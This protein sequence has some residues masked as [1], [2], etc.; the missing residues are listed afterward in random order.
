MTPG[1]ASRIGGSIRPANRAGLRC[2]CRE[3]AVHRL[4]PVRA[5]GARKARDIVLLTCLNGAFLAR[6]D[7]LNI[8]DRSRDQLIEPMPALRDRGDELGAGFGADRTG[9]GMRGCRRGENNLSRSF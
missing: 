1:Q 4:R 9:V 6:C 5:L 2:Q 8:R 3:V 7:L